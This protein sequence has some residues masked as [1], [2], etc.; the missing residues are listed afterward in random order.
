VGGFAHQ[1]LVADV[2]LKAVRQFGDP[3][4]IVN[5]DIRGIGCRIAITGPDPLRTHVGK[6]VDV[7]QKVSGAAEEYSNRNNYNS[8]SHNHL[9]VA[10]GVAFWNRPY[11]KERDVVK[12][13]LTGQ[14]K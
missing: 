5:D 4:W 13:K 6:V 10:K 2:D 11:S 1:G 12:K 3:P 7:S 8:E 9:L 14:F